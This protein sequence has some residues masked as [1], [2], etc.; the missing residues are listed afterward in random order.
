MEPDPSQMR[1]VGRKIPLLQNNYKLMS[2]HHQNAVKN[3]N[4]QTNN[5]AYKN[6]TAFEYMG[7]T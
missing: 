5:K 3:H 1:I 6:L 2:H 4:V 7:R